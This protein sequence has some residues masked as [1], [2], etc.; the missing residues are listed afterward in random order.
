MLQTLKQLRV[1]LLPHCLIM[2]VRL[3]DHTASGICPPTR[4]L[5]AANPKLHPCE[6]GYNA[7]HKCH[8]LGLLMQARLN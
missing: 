2:A 1:L 7:P 5:L 4:K 8:N 6:L 3:P